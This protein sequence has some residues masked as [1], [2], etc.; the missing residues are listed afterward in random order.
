M[1]ARVCLCGGLIREGSCERCSR[2][3]DRKRPQRQTAAQ[4][5]YGSRW[6]EAS[7]LFLSRQE[8]W[9][10]VQCGRLSEVTDHIVPH[11]G[12]ERLFWDQRNWQPLC[13]TCHDSKTQSERAARARG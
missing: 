7:R 4:R 6:R 2:R 8:N 10:C 5:G 12:D 9:F 3:D 13:K 1:R 11:R